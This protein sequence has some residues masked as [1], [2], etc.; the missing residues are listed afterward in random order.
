MA[1]LEV[2]TKLPMDPHRAWEKASRLQ[3]FDEWLTIHDGWRSELPDTLTAGTTL[4]SVVSVKGLRN[5]VTWTVVELDAPHHVVLRGTGKAGTKFSMRLA[6]TAA[7]EGSRLTM[8]IDLGGAPLFGPIGSGVARALQGDLQA[9][10]DTFA[11]LY[12]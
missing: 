8:K 3:S 9:S 2:S 4:Q 10:L 1:K 11:R 5:R 12:G 6:V 7:G